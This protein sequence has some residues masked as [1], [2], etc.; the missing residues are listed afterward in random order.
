MSRINDVNF[1]R[2]SVVNNDASNYA[3]GGALVL[4]NFLSPATTLELVRHTYMMWNM[5]FQNNSVSCQFA[6]SSFPT[7]AK[8]CG[9]GAMMVLGVTPDTDT[10]KT[11]PENQVAML[12]STFTGNDVTVDGGGGVATSFGGAVLG[13]AF[14]IYVSF[15]GTLFERNR[16]V[17]TNGAEGNGGAVYRNEDDVR[18]FI[19]FGNKTMFRDN[20]ASTKGNTMSITGGKAFYQLPAPAGQFIQGQKCEVKRQVCPFA[21]ATDPS[22]TSNTDCTSTTA[23]CA[24]TTGTTAPSD[25]AITCRPT[26]DM[27]QEC[28]WDQLGDWILGMNMETLQQRSIEDDYPYE[29]TRGTVG[30]SAFDGQMSSACAGECPAGFYCPEPMTTT[31]KPCRAGNY[32]PEGSAQPIPCSAGTYTRWTDRTSQTD[33]NYGC[34]ACPAG[35]ACVAGST[36]PVPCP[37]GQYSVGTGAA[38]CTQCGVGKYSNTTGATA[39]QTCGEGFYSSNVLSCLRAQRSTQTCRTLTDQG[40]VRPLT[41]PSL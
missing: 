1:L 32:C 2:N 20:F 3:I 22:A 5:L 4:W 6:S 25:S 19:H 14:E 18:G 7:K 24:L 33:P 38:T 34:D 11:V 16:A 21:L 36:A 31:P 41:H 26:T 12:E 28:Q 8:I 17:G 10:S 30:S 35:S 13:W 37:L 15:V 39:C 23:E 9:G 40:C 27:L 29:C